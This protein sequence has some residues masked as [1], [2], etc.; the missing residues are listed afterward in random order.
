[1]LVVILKRYDQKQRKISR[2][3]T[4]PK[5]IDLSSVCRKA[6]GSKRRL[7]DAGPSHTPSK[8]SKFCEG[9]TSAEEEERQLKAALRN[10]LALS[11]QETDNDAELQTVLELSLAEQK[12]TFK[13]FNNC[14]T[15][16]KNS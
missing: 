5:C 11:H 13:L 2:K 1:M 12:S 6:T 10:S 16:N 9:P 14:F 7:F 3:V 15:L 4:V 8:R